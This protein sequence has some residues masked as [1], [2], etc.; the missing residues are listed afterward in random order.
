M[1]THMILWHYAAVPSPRDRMPRPAVGPGWL[2]LVVRAWLRR[3]VA[4]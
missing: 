3:H 4:I 1:Q 2:A